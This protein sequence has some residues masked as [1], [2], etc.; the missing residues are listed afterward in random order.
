MKICNICHLWICSHSFSHLWP[1]NENSREKHSPW[2]TNSLWQAF[3]LS[4]IINKKTALKRL[5]AFSVQNSH[6]KRSKI[7]IRVGGADENFAT[8]FS[9]LKWMPNSVSKV[10][11]LKVRLWWWGRIWVKLCFSLIQG[12][13]FLHFLYPLSVKH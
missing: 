12:Q 5:A 10:E 6:N 8:Q 13:L 11:S 9:N 1:W 4:F 2:L 3:S 7:C